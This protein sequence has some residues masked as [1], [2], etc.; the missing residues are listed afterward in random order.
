MKYYISL[1]GGGSRLTG[2]LFDEQG[3]VLSFAEGA[4]VNPTVYSPKQIDEHIR[5]VINSLLD[6]TADDVREIEAVY[7]SSHNAY[8]AVIEERVPCREVVKLFEGPFGALCCGIAD[9]VCCLSGTGSD[10]FL[11]QG[12]KMADQL[13]GW[14]YLLGDDG[15]GSY[16]GQ[17]AL[18]HTMAVI[19]KRI[20]PTLLSQMVCA[21]TGCDTWGGMINLLYKH[22]S[23]VRFMASLC[24]VVATAEAEGDDTAHEILQDAGRLLGETCLAIIK[25]HGA[26]DLPI[27]TTGSVLLHCKTVFDRMAETVRGE[28]PAARILRPSFK[29]VM[30]GLIYRI[31]KQQG[32][33]PAEILQ[34]LKQRYPELT[35]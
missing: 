34:N 23:P 19:E 14:G 35:V 10:A 8:A 12:G 32:N 28:I 29:P 18:R 31:Y 2:I 11:V 4:G 26:H 22:E 1:D 6:G 3:A 15:G 24:T 7:Q 33:L 25:K 20:K 9:G 5:G 27:A 30:G 16:I 21:Y 13:G 17:Q